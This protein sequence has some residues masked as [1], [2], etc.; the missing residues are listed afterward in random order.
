M[1]TIRG[2]GFIG[3]TRERERLDAVLAQARDGHSAVLVL[4]GEP[5]IGKTALLRYAARQA[6]GLRTTEVDGI[7]A[8]MELSFAGIHR[9]CTPILDKIEVLAEP[10]QNALRV[11]WGMASGDAPDRFLVAVAVLNLLS[12]TA[13]KRPLSGST[14]PLCRRWGSSRGAW[15]RSR[16]R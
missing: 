5:G 11:A 12:A 10:Q 4:R 7:Q 15:R 3:R 2:V 9:L 6:S 13:E 14:P 16:W 1:P 8:E